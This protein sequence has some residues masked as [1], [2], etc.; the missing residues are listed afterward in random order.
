MCIRDSRLGECLTFNPLN[1]SEFKKPPR[2]LKITL[3]ARIYFSSQSGSGQVTY[4][5]FAGIS[6]LNVMAGYLGIS[7]SRL[8]C[9]SLL[10][11]N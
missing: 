11:R 3:S 6:A 4:S 2:D 1:K 7:D 9:N 10:L 5:I 8:C